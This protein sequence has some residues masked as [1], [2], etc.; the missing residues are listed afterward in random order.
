MRLPGG[1]PV[2]FIALVAY[3][4]LGSLIALLAPAGALINTSMGQRIVRLWHRGLLRILGL[5]LTVSGRP[6]QPPALIVANHISWVDIPALGAICSGHFVAK[7]EIAKW[8]IL[9]WLAAQAGTYYIKRGNKS[10]SAAV[11]TCMTG[12]FQRHESVLLFPEGTSTD[13]TQVR[14]FHARLFVAAIESACPVQPVAISYPGANGSIHPAA[15]FIGDDTLLAHI[16]RLL[17]ARGEITIHLHFLASQPITDPDARAIAERARRAVA[18]HH[19]G[20]PDET[21]KSL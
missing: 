12:A 1:A 7:A 9:G 11:A 2:R 15:P 6:P 18:A 17:R 10:A 4:F 13:G 5:R 19:K 20:G 14:L 3:G 21:A 8:P 16:W